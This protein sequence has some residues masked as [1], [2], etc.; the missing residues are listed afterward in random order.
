MKI[1]IIYGNDVFAL[2]KSEVLKKLGSA[3]LIDIKLLLLICADNECRDNF[4]SDTVAKQLNCAKSDVEAALK[5][6]IGADV[7]KST[8]IKTQKSDQQ[9]PADVKTPLR[10]IDARPTYTGKEINEIVEN[11]KNL[12][13]LIDECANVVGKVLNT[14]EIQKILGL[15]DYLRLDYEHIMMIFMYCKNQ[16]KLSIAYIEKFAYTLFDEGI[17][18]LAKFDSY[19]K[20]REEFTE[21]LGQLRK[22]FGMG[23]REPTKDENKFFTRWCLEWMFSYEIIKRAYEITIANTDNHKLS[24]S[25]M[26]KVL[27]NWHKD[28]YTTIEAIETAVAARQQDK[29]MASQ[30]KSSFDTDEFF[31]LALKRTYEEIEKDKDKDKEV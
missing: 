27:D 9:K 26:N 25:Y 22:L 15:V 24:Y 5:F 7:L 13:W 2:P 12:R 23:T 19:V 3:E 16:G 18:T 10:D 28:G 4:N 21:I 1:D 14:A 29:E 6:W 8:D 30:S 20:A 31:E 17:D 11:N